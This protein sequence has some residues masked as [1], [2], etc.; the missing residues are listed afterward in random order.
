[1]P[2]PPSPPPAPASAS[3]PSPP[4]PAGS[5]RCVPGSRGLP[6]GRPQL[7][8]LGPDRDLGAGDRVDLSGDPLRP[9]PLAQQV[10]DQGRHVLRLPDLRQLHRHPGRHP[11]P[12]HRGD[13]VGRDPVPMQA[14]RRAADQGDDPALGRAVVGLGHAPL[15]VA[16]GEADQCAAALLLAHDRRRGPEDRE[17]ALQVGGE[18][19]VP[20]LL[21]HVEE[22]P[23]TQDPGH[24]DD[25][26]EPSVL[27]QR[28]LHDPLSARH[29]GDVV[30]H[31]DRLPAR[32]PDL[33]GDRPRDLAGR[34]GAVDGDAVVVDDDPRPLRRRRER[35][36]PSDA[37]AGPRDG[38]HPACQEVPHVRPFPLFLTDR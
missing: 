28:R 11:G 10:D 21:G 27:R 6:V 37:P 14:E 24:A 34:R 17:R 32:R 12:G 22:H 4:S 3:G 5:P 35:D 36:R 15:V 13:R 7:P 8:R 30:G 33:L 2:P 18:D 19:R 1:M 23:F 26:V 25:P 9:R 16:A 20:L 29:R 31:R 38:D